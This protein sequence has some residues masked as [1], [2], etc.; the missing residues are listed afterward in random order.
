VCV[1]V[2][3]AVWSSIKHISAKKK[4]LTD[5]FGFADASR[6]VFGQH[7]ATF[8]FLDIAIHFKKNN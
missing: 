1:A 6:Y 5:N 7:T 2:C 3:V 8:F 4:S